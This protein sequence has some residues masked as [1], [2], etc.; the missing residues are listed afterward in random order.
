MEFAGIQGG[1]IHQGE[2]IHKVEGGTLH[3]PRFFLGERD[4]E[5]PGVALGLDP[6]RGELSSRGRARARCGGRQK[7]FPA[8]ASDQ[9]LVC[10]DPHHGALRV[11]VHVAEH[12]DLGGDEVE[13]VAQASEGGRGGGGLSETIVDQ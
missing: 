12:Q 1:E 3:G 7:F 4:Q 6:V 8:F 9:E 2:E 13:V 10:L 11:D 5:H